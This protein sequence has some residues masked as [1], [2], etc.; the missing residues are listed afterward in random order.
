MGRDSLTE[1]YFNKKGW[2]D[3]DRKAWREMTEEP[4]IVLT[5]ME[6]F[7]QGLKLPELPQ[8]VT[9]AEIV[10]VMAER[11]REIEGAVQEQAPMD[12]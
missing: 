9:Y 7:F 6:K 10:E 3:W 5:D 4:C 11:D 2:D 8:K 1:E 12:R